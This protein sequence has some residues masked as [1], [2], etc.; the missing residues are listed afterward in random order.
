MRFKKKKRGRT[1]YENVHKDGG[2]LS[3]RQSVT[4]ERRPS[5]RYGPRQSLVNK[6]IQIRSDFKKQVNYNYIISN[7]LKNL[8]CEDFFYEDSTKY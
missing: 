6:R 8:G 1:E 4:F 5:Q 3:R 2:R 7:L